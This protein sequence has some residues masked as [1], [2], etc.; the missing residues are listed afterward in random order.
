MLNQKNEF[1]NDIARIKENS[2]LYDL[3]SYAVHGVLVIG[4]KP[5]GLD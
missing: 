3:E 4:T 5:E 2:R 1:Q